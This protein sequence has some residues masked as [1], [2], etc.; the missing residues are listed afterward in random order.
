MN[1]E[2]L[3]RLESTDVLKDAW[4]H[5]EGTHRTAVRMAKPNKNLAGSQGMTPGPLS[6]ALGPSCLLSNE[7]SPQIGT[8]CGSK[9]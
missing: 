9:K 4:G 5:V 7:T 3:I 6:T 8:E 1:L 2:C